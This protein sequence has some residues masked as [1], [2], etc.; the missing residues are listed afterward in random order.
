MT[1]NQVNVTVDIFKQVS[2]IEHYKYLVIGHY[3]L[4]IKVYY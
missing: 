3:L 1:S 2:Y 4:I